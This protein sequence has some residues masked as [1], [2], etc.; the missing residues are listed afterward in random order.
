MSD[1]ITSPVTE[2]LKIV[3]YPAVLAAINKRLLDEGIAIIHLE[4][5]D[6]YV[7]CNK[8]DTGYFALSGHLPI[9]EA[10]SAAIEILI[11]GVI[12]EVENGGR[13]V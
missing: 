13:H 3:D 2:Q 7:V 6:S 9:A 11:D 8:T 5:D 10:Y 12:W 4:K 1:Y